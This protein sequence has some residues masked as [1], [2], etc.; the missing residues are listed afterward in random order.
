MAALGHCMTLPLPPTRSPSALAEKRLAK[1]VH[2]SALVATITVILGIGASLIDKPIEI[3]GALGVLVALLVVI[4]WGLM[5]QA[6]L[7]DT[8]ERRSKIWAAILVVPFLGP[9][10]YYWVVWRSGHA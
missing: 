6:F 7:R 8:S 4:H 10:A 3:G 5:W 2:V 1:L 9:V